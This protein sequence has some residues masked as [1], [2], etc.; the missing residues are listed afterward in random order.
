MQ[1]RAFAFLIGITLILA[2]GGCVASMEGA[3]AGAGGYSYIKGELKHTYS[4]PVKTLWP[5]TLAAMN[6]LDLTVKEKYVLEFSKINPT[7]FMD[8][9]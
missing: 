3:G 9:A 5:H 6:S 2:S 8:L 1:Q 4:M 7:K